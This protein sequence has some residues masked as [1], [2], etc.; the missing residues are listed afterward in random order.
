MNKVILSGRL[1]ADPEVRYT[2]ATPS[3]AIARYRLAVDRR[4]KNG[5]READF[6]NCLAFDKRAEF[7]DKYFRKGT[8]IMVA[9]RLQ[10]GSYTKQDGTKVYTTDVVID[11][12]EFAESKNAG[13]QQEAPAAKIKPV[14]DEGFMTIPDDIED[15]GLPFN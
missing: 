6:I 7:A 2:Q 1:V 15:G 3:M 10:T 8:K 12:H 5:E 11:E 13:S 9:G 14:A 4:G